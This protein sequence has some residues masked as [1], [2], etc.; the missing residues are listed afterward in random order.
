[1]VKSNIIVAAII[2]FRAGDATNYCIFI[3]SS[4]FDCAV[5][6]KYNLAEIFNISV[7]CG[8]S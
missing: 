7:Y 6:S 1:L 4:C 8:Y 3:Q 2:I 5:F